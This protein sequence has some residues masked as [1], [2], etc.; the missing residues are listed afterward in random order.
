MNDTEDD[1]L[2]TFFDN[3]NMAQQV[4]GFDNMF[5]F[6]GKTLSQGS[7]SATPFGQPNHNIDSSSSLDPSQP[8]YQSA[9]HMN[10]MSGHYQ[11]HQLQ[12]QQ[13][14]FTNHT[15]SLDDSTSQTQTQTMNNAD[16][17]AASSLWDFARTI[18]LQHNYSQA[19]NGEALTGSWGTLTVGQHSNMPPGPSG[20]SYPNAPS[21]AGRGEAASFMPHAQ[22]HGWAEN[23]DM[24]H[25]NSPQQPARGAEPRIPMHLNPFGG[26]LTHLSQP[27][28][29]QQQEQPRHYPGVKFG[30]D[31]DYNNNTNHYQ[32]PR[33]TKDSSTNLLNVP[34]A[35]NVRESF[36]PG[37]MADQQVDQQSGGSWGTLRSGGFSRPSD[38]DEVVTGPQPHKR[39]QKGHGEHDSD[40]AWDPRVSQHLEGGSQ[41][42]KVEQNDEEP[43]MPVPSSSTISTASGKR[44]RTTDG[45][46]S[47]VLDSPSGNPDDDVAEAGEGSARK[48]GTKSRLNLTE[49]QK[50]KNHIQ[51][52]KKRREIIQQGYADLNKLVPSLAKGKSGLSRSEC[53]H[54]IG[55]YLEVIRLGNAK[56]QEV[57]GDNFDENHPELLAARAKWADATARI[58]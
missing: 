2:S 21:T 7:F 9:H 29:P 14:S 25:A 44:R 43:S 39:H 38:E 45:E 54:E 47:Q 26:P 58:E 48:R 22:S 4:D 19:T 49:E 15:G 5:N 40:H 12:Q 31:P 37:G 23:R 41:T 28:P 6:G 36:A 30:T 55:Q 11:Q 32:G 27:N 51:S 24:S 13:S 33:H 46:T 8:S 50:R 1:Y 17:N 57:L 16:M 42:I 52:E 3:P 18:P 53:L 34:L 56:M 10:N 20:G 35:V